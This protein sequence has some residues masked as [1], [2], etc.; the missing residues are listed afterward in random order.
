M[1]TQ[2]ISRKDLHTLYES[3][4]NC[5]TWKKKIEETL[6]LQQ[7]NTEIE[8]PEAIIVEAYSQAN[9]EQKK[10]LDKFFDVKTPEKVLS[11]ISNIKDVLSI[12]GKKLVDVLPYKKASNKAQRSQNALALIQVIT[13]AYCKV[14]GITLDW[15]NRSQRK[16]FIW[17]EKQPSGRWSFV[18]C[19]TT[20]T[21][22]SLGFGS[23]FP[24]EEAARDASVKFKDVFLDYLPE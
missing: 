13:E 2:K 20:A 5:A 16:Y 18:M 24:S 15:S 3:V 17:W 14:L 4:K 21:V 23:Y 22:R 8:V 7:V 11:K 9:S 1:S 19:I 6:I 12:T 10:L